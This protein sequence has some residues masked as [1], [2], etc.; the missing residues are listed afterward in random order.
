MCILASA[1]VSLSEHLITL[2]THTLVNSILSPLVFFAMGWF[3][4]LEKGLSPVG[5]HHVYASSKAP[6]QTMPS[7]GTVCSSKETVKYL[8]E[9][10]LFSC[11]NTGTYFTTAPGN[12]QMKGEGTSRLHRF[13]A[14]QAR[15]VERLSCGCLIGILFYMRI[16]LLLLVTSVVFLFYICDST[17]EKSLMSL[18]VYACGFMSG[19]LFGGWDDCRS[20][21]RWFLS[22]MQW[23]KFN[24]HHDFA[25]TLF[26]WETS[27]FYTK[28]VCFGNYYAI[29][30]TTCI[31]LTVIIWTARYFHFQRTA[32]HHMKLL[33]LFLLLLMFLMLIYTLKGHKELRFIHNVFLIFLVTFSFSIC[34]LCHVCSLVGLDV[35]FLKRISFMLILCCSVIRLCYIYSNIN[36]SHHYIK[37]WF[38]RGDPTSGHVNSCIEF[39]GQQDDAKG[40]FLDR[41]IHLSG[42][43]T[44]LHKNIP[45]FAQIHFEYHE[46]GMLARKRLPINSQLVVHPGQ[47][48]ELAVLS[49]ITN[50]VTVENSPLVLKYLFDDVVYNYIVTGR[51]SSIFQPGFSTVHQSGGVQ[52]L[53]RENHPAATTSASDRARGI[54]IGTNATVLE[55]EGSWLY[56][57]GL[58]EK[59]I[60]RLEVALQL[61]R[62]RIKVYQLLSLSYGAIGKVSF[63]NQVFS[64]CIALYGA[65]CSQPQPKVILHKDLDL[66]ITME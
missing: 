4:S 6:S 35:K 61:D 15:L 21:G 9:V 27:T 58:Y 64:Q 48:V 10:D 55:Y 65:D 28:E 24:I 40:L 50:Y 42:G 47:T 30:Q 17:I 11:C 39:I 23:Y 46:F 44:I 66:D 16:D 60:E 52:V 49:K 43:Y 38:Y 26:G 32:S 29:C 33:L 18:G 62:S 36:E 2:G 5:P 1:L 8:P 53:R 19:V 25:T 14:T 45:I 34:T 7:K 57:Y 63:G 59:A 3:I 22:P 41:T 37:K 54:P 20:Y 51:N 13:D 12:I 56:T 31:V